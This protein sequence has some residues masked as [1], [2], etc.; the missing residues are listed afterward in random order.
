MP[1]RP[2]ME[3]KPED[4]QAL[5]GSGLVG[6]NLAQMRR[7]RPQGTPSVIDLI[8]TGR[9]RYSRLDPTEHWQTY[10]QIVRDVQSQG[11]TDADCED[12]ASLVAAEYQF[13]GEDPGAQVHVYGTGPNLSHVVVRRSN[14]ALEDPSVAAGMGSAVQRERDNRVAAA[15]GIR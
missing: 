6:V 4:A 8:R 13:T 9:V 15:L 7:L 2:T 10:E 12:L 14:G 1:I 11:W 3:I 5:L